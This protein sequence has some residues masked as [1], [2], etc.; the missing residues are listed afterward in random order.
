MVVTR[1]RA[2]VHR[3]ATTA[4]VT[5]SLAVAAVVVVV[6]VMRPQPKATQ[7]YAAVAAVMALRHCCPPVVLVSDCMPLV[8]GIDEGRG[9]CLARG[10]FRGP[11]E[12]LWGLIDDIGVGP[13]GVSA[14]WVPSHRSSSRFP[15]LSDDWIDAR[16]NQ[17]VNLAAK[18]G[19]AMHPWGDDAELRA[20]GL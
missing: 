18:R 7:A 6:T 5:A 11:W 13:T 2:I 14:R 16:G 1:N 4:S 8:S 15:F 3:V 19:A 20:V 12:A 9:A 17:L 10:R